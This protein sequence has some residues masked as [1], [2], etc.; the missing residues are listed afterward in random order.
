MRWKSGIFL[1]FRAF[2]DFDDFLGNTGDFFEKE[3][4]VLS[5]WLEGDN[6]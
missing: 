6:Q 2:S 1:V 4:I 5:E 3:E